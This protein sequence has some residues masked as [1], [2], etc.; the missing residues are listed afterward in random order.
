V[1]DIAHF[2]GG[3]EFGQNSARQGPVYQPSTGLQ[4]GRVALASPSEVDEAVKI[5]RSAGDQW[6]DAPLGTRVAVMER[7]RELLAQRID[8]V[9]EVISRENGKLF[10]D[11]KGEV[12]RGLESVEFACGA[13]THLLGAFSELVSSDI[14]TYSL[15]QAVGVV[16][17]ITPANFPA[18]VP[19]WMLP[20]AI[21]CGNAV[22]FKPS[23]KDPSA[24]LLLARLFQ[25]AGLPDGVLNV[26]NGDQETVRALLEH[27]GV[28][29]VSF[30][31]STPVARA[32]YQAASAT[33]KRV[34]ALG[35]AKNHLIVLPDADLD[36]AA[37]A[38]V[39]A[40]YGAAG[41][42]CM[43][44]SVV[45]PVG[46]VADELIQELGKR[47]KDVKVGDSMDLTAQLGPLITE[48]H[49]DRVASYL[50]SSAEKGA[51][52]VVDGTD[53]VRRPGFFLGPC[54]LDNVR[55]DMDAYRDE[56]FGP[57][58]S[59]VHAATYQ[60][61]VEVVNANPFGNG[62]ALFTTS[63]KA[64]RVFQ[65]EARIGMLGVNVPIPVPPGHFSFGG[66]K[67]SL[68]GDLHMYGPEGIKFFSRGKTVMTRW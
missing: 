61:A 52:V 39:S 27:P 3:K 10:L 40:G 6:R 64:A 14:D 21:V 62:A 17:A 33:G 19:L 65:R 1:Y 24:A 18:M 43:A 36:L 66:W 35:G 15:R 7:F 63:G 5:A 50:S 37:D 20:N 38:A 53:E 9:A 22:L 28:D 8:E 26:V 54:L 42:R 32:I 57:V 13:P 44:V 46:G 47:A 45:V 29:A 2:I 23:E 59:V 48:Q 49:R 25:E 60:E 51:K 30:V 31:G 16:A 11:A 34:Q 58:L 55:V 68:F 41:Q 4:V 56:I 67:G 12:L